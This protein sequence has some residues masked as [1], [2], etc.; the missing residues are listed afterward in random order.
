M[1]SRLPQCA[2]KPRST[3]ALEAWRHTDS[4]PVRST[5][6]RS[7][8]SSA[9]KSP[10]R[11]RQ[12]SQ[13]HATGAADDLLPF[14]RA[15]QP[16]PQGRLRLSGSPDLALRVGPLD[17][18]RLAAR[19]LGSLRYGLFASLAHL[20]RADRPQSPADLAAHERLM[21][22]TGSVTLLLEACRAGLGI[23]RL[24]LPAVPAGTRTRVL[25]DRAPQP[26][27][28]HA[29]LPS[30]RFVA[31]KVRAFIGHTAVRRARARNAVAPAPGRD[32]CYRRPPCPPC[33][34]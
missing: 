26:V 19:L 10:C 20:A 16:E 13:W 6:S 4:A 17:D 3:V 30:N 5:A 2:Q 29:G 31:P 25:P 22:S 11:R 24:P 1:N 33:S 28:V 15:Q 9:K 14:A 7:A 27:P 8:G 34:T 12:S 18:S 23:A 32:C 21:F